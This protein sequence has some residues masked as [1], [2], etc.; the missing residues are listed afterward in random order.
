MATAD[1]IGAGKQRIVM[2]SVREIFRIAHGMS[3]WPQ[4]RAGFSRAVGEP[5]EGSVKATQMR[6][7]MTASCVWLLLAGLA[8]TVS[9]H[10]GNAVYDTRKSVTVTGSVTK[11]QLINPHAGL[12]IEV[13]TDSGSTELWSGEFGGVLDLYRTFKWNKDTFKPGDRVTLI[14]NPARDG[15]TALLAREVVMADGRRIDLEG[16]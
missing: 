14:G 12:W 5:G 4:R 2:S 15:S 9:A 8:A 7:A 6:L 3:A 1:G 13:K 10:H 16:T 11:W